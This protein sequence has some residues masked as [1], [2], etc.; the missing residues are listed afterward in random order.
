MP[1]EIHVNQAV[2]TK[3][4]ANH[5]ETSD[6]LA[7]VSASHEDIRTMLSSLGPIYGDLRQAADAMLD[8]RKRCYDSQSSEHST[9]AGNLRDAVSRWNKHEED[10]AR[11]FRGLTD[12]R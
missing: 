5:Q 6:Y 12:G 3:A 2:L 10:A 8:A 1:Q 9:M 11:S 4:A 7:T